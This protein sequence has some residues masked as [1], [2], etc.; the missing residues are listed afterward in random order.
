MNPQSSQVGDLP[1]KLVRSITQARGNRDHWENTQENM[2][3]MNALVD[4]RR[5]YEQQ[6][7]KLTV[8]A[9]MDTEAVGEGQFSDFRDKPLVFEREIA[10]DDPGRTTTLTLQRE[11]QGR[12]YY[13]T[14]LR[15]APLP[16]VAERMNAGMD[17]R[18]EYSVERDGKWVLLEPPFTIKRGELVRVD[19]YLSIPTARHF[20]V[21][22]DAVPGGLEPVNRDLAT[23]SIVDA[24]KGLFQAAGG[25]WWFQYADWQAF[26][27]S[28]WSFYHQELRHD[29]ARFYADYLEAWELPSVLHCP[30]HSDRQLRRPTGLCRRNVRP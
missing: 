23:A 25:S 1:L 18:R 2:F 24:D 15:Y 17:I 9:R 14:R 28:R 3:C 7:P 20:V 30:G 11:G 6:K 5:Q 19:L 27:A 13:A 21:V 26:Q 10:T 8:R 22:D 12:A 4:Y 29:S 16:E